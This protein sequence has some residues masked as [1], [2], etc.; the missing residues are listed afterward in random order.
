MKNV[1]SIPFSNIFNSNKQFQKIYTIN[2]KIV[3]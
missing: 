2:K 1:T 3:I